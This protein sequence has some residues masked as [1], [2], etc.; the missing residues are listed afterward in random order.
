MFYF[1]SSFFIICDG[2]FEMGYYVGKEKQGESGKTLSLVYPSYAKKGGKNSDQKN[3]FKKI[4]VDLIKCMVLGCACKKM[5]RGFKISVLGKEW[6]GV[7]CDKEMYV[8]WFMSCLAVFVVFKAVSQK[9]VVCFSSLFYW[10]MDGG[11]EN[12]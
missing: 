12:V 3:G 1:F 4:W 8:L 5:G 11:G 7:A 6:G 9:V 2:V 10:S